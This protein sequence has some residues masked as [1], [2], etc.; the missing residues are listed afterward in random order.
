MTIEIIVK[1]MNKVNATR[2]LQKECMN[3]RKIPINQKQITTARYGGPFWSKLNNLLLYRI[4]SL[5]HYGKIQL[6]G[7][8]YKLI[9]PQIFL[10]A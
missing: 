5:F 4:P 10:S 7:S 1:P 6:H 8:T 3:P 9:L 2:K